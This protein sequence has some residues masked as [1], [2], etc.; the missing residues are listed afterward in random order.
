MAK[1]Y[2]LLSIVSVSDQETLSKYAKIAGSIIQSKADKFFRAGM[3]SKFM[4]LVSIKE[5]LLSSSKILKKQFRRTKVLT[6]KQ[7]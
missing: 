2:L 3:R 1:G 5:S 7:L 6:I 4:K